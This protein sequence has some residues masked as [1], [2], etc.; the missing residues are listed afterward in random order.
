MHE[1]INADQ[2]KQQCALSG[3]SSFDF[4][5]E[6]ALDDDFGEAITS[7]SVDL[8]L[9]LTIFLTILLIFSTMT[10]TNRPIKRRVPSS[11]K[12][13]SAKYSSPDCQVSDWSAWTG[14]SKSCG[15]GET[16]RTRQI[17]KHPKRGGLP[18]P[19]LR[20]TSWCGSSRTCNTNENYFKW[21]I[22]LFFRWF[23]AFLWTWRWH[24]VGW[25]VTFCSIKSKI[26]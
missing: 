19:N 3:L 17:Q 15:L 23:W 6:N 5:F 26:H 24:C 20:Q 10:Y 25:G 9:F 16:V 12:E 4:D 18:C 13:F 7:T 8:L 22:N 2:L 11:S 1:F 14:C 21:W